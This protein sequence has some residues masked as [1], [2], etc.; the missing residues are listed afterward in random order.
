M[1]FGHCLCLPTVQ[2][3]HSRPAAGGALRFLPFLPA[4]AKRD[5]IEK[6]RGE[7]IRKRKLVTFISL[8]LGH[9]E[10][11]EAV[12]QKAHDVLQLPS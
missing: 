6:G 10:K 5:G 2:K 7:I 4:G 11:K 12:W 8:V 1:T 3:L 9:S